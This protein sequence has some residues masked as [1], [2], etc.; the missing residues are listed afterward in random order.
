MLVN[1]N[2]NEAAGAMF[3]K[4]IAAN[5]NY[6]D[7]HYQYGIYLIGKATTT[8]DGKIVPP[9]GTAEEFQKYLELKPDGSNAEAAKGMLASIGAKIEIDYS[10]PGAKRP[11]ATK[12]KP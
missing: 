6:A 3:K 5:T 2:Q 10:K 7:A 9:E 4:A 1:L 11:A 8:P 12:K